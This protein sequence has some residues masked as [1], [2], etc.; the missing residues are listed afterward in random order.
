M[1]LTEKTSAPL[2][3]MKR[4]MLVVGFLLLPLMACQ[5]HAQ[6]KILQGK[7]FWT[8]FDSLGDGTPWQQQF[9]DMTGCIFYPKLNR[10]HISYGGSDSAPATM[11]G[12]LG[13][14]KLLVALKDSLPIDI[15]MISN[16]NDMNFTDPDTGVEGSIDDE[17][18]MQGCK[19][20]VT[21]G[22]MESKEAAKAYCQKNLRKILKATP[23]SQRG[24][25]NMLVFPYAEPKRHGNRIEIKA[26]S[27]QGG[28]ICFHVGRSPRVNLTLPAGMSV[29][30][31]REWLSSKFY[32]AGWSAVDNGDNSFTISYYY[33]KNNKVR[34]DTK[35]SG[36]Q[37]EVTDGP[38]VEEYVYYYTGKDASGWTKNSNWTEKISLWSCYKGL[39]EYLQANLPNT[40][41]YWFM[42]SYFNFDF[43]TPELLRADGSF[44]EEAFKKTERNRKWMQLS[45]MQRAIAH[46]YNCGVLEVGKYCGITLG[47]VRD[48]YNSKDPH[49]KKEGYAQWSK[50]LYEIFS[51]GKWE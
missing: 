36:L 4:S 42:P 21:P 3:T 10:R 44:D 33:D 34:V 17:P 12:T 7:G 23:K 43:D 37:V 1:K 27:K 35:E 32:G 16:T 45:A 28:E 8:L 46:R 26:A 14:A 48:Y 47:N 15:I 19:R 31:T 51:Q 38:R 18:W 39:M 9:A 25:G 20:T 5:L 30:E 50:A 13:R 24:A 22:L 11:N 29:K 6:E 40:Q 2:Y 49:L 41:I